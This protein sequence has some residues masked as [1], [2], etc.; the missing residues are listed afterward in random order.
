MALHAGIKVK[1][2]LVQVNKQIRNPLWKPKPEKE[3]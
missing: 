2:V 1:Q 3:V